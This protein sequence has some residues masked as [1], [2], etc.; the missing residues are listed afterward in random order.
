MFIRK[1]EPKSGQQLHIN[2]IKLDLA[3]NKYPN[4]LHNQTKLKTPANPTITKKQQKGLPAFRG[5]IP[6]HLKKHLNTIN[7]N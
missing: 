4:K 5:Q 2:D 1:Q 6:Q 3:N 7:S